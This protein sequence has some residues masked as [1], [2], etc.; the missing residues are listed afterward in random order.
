MMFARTDKTGLLKI[1]G[2][3]ILIL[4]AFVETTRGSPFI[5][6]E[7]LGIALLSK[8]TSLAL[9]WQDSGSGT[10]SKSHIISGSCGR[11]LVEFG[12]FQIWRPLRG[13]AEKCPNRIC[14][15]SPFANGGHFSKER[16]HGGMTPCFQGGDS[17]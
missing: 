3:T 16:G 7:E 13:Q 8:E 6:R 11:E 5:R 17:R 15:L 1:E 12:H 2:W 10:S 14:R 9:Y 4:A